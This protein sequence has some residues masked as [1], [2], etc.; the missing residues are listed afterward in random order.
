VQS[1]YSLWH[2]AP[3]REILPT[4]EELG[5][6]FV[7]FGPLGQGFLTGAIDALT[8]LAPDD[9]RSMLPRFSAEARLANRALVEVLAQLAV[10][11]TVTPAQLALAWLLAKKPWIVP[12][13]GTRK[14][15]HLAE[16]IRAASVSLTAD[17]LAAI[18]DAANRIAIQGARLPQLFEGLS[19]R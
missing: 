14:V 8:P 6:G 9:F 13:P 19:G 10:R 2:R 16:N 1:E 5:V 12:I 7:A 15:D 4:L 11:L 17:D 3:E 18:D